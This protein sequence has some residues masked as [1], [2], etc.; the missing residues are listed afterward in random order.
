MPA[1]RERERLMMAA[2]RDVTEARLP[3]PELFRQLTP[4]LRGLIGCDAL[5]LHSAD[6]VTGFITSTYADGL[7]PEGF[8]L[9]AHLEL[10]SD[11]STRFSSIRG[12]GRLAASLVDTHEGEPERSVRY[13]ELL[14][15]FGFTDELR[16]AFD[17]RGGLWGA[18][19][20][21]RAKGRPAYQ[22]GDL[23]LAERAAR[24][25]A[26][27]LRT[28]FLS[29]GTAHIDGDQEPAMFVLDPSGRLT[30]ANR[31]AHALLDDL[32][33]AMRLPSGLP[34]AF[35]GIAE[36]ARRSAAGV[37]TGGP[38]LARVRTLSGRW[39]T[40]HASLLE[41]GPEGYVAVVV[42][43]ASPADYMP[44]AL[45]AH[46]FSPRE[47]A[48]V[49]EVLR[50][51][52]THD[53]ARSLVLTPATVQDHLKSVFDK[54]GVRSRRELVALLMTAQLTGAAPPS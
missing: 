52:S 36:H 26:A 44:V 15:P 48:V 22:A 24:A 35:A 45:L 42:T 33:D 49:V 37:G 25:V 47:Q 40:L 32:V 39:L 27:A 4:I 28:Y 2:I 8:T 46:G 12:R 18:A 34:T 21:M 50:G 23:R 14:A 43:P 19:A 54:T 7:D 11:D 16:I 30:F 1:H 3:L 38:S 10:W 5:C 41:T 9:A 13:R 29:S 53:I 31:Q 6:P 17:L 51:R 20:L